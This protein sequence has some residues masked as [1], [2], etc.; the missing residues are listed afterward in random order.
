[1]ELKRENRGR[2]GPEK[3][4]SHYASARPSRHATDM[5]CDHIRNIPLTRNQLF[6]ANSH[7][8][9]SVFFLCCLA[10]FSFFFCRVIFVPLLWRASDLI[11]SGTPTGI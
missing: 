4:S 9:L 6:S 7:N 8:L 1:M 10:V 5:Y 2:H 3:R 11:R